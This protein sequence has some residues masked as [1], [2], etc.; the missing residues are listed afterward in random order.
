MGWHQHQHRRSAW[1]IRPLVR[2]THRCDE[3]SPTDHCN[4]SAVFVLGLRVLLAGLTPAGVA[5]SWLLGTLVYAAFG[6][7]GYLLVCI[8]F[9]AG[10]A[11]RCLRL[12]LHSAAAGPIVCS[13]SLASD[14]AIAGA[15]LPMSG[16]LSLRRLRK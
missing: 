8:Y 9:I 4:I 3:A 11:V 7:T 12:R 15:M 2:M 16:T 10:S 13:C 5:N 1:S 6:W 14:V